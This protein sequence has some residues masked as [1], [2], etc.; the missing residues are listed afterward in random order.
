M[1]DKLIAY[2]L[3]K[4]G[5]SY[6]QIAEVLHLGKTTVYEYVKEQKLLLEEHRKRKQTDLDKAVVAV[7]PSRPLERGAGEEVP[8]LESLHI[9]EFTGDELLTKVFDCLDFEGRFLELIGKPSRLFSAIIWGMPK[10]GKSNFALRFA[11]YLQ[12]YFGRVLYIA[13]EEG[14]SVTLQEKFR[15]IGGSKVT[16]IE[17]RNRE[18]IRVFLG[19]RQEFGFVFIDSINNAGI[20][21]E[22]LELLKSENRHCSFI[23]VVQATKGG[24]FKGDQA[25]T[26]NC[27]FIIA[28]D[29]GMAYH[30]GR[31][32][33]NTELNIF[34][35]G[36]WY[37]KNPMA[38]EQGFSKSIEAPLAQGQRDKVL[39]GTVGDGMAEEDAQKKV[40]LQEDWQAALRKA[41]EEIERQ[42]KTRLQVVK[43]PQKEAPLTV[44]EFFNRLSKPTATKVGLA[45]FCYLIADGLATWWKSRHQK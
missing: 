35:G 42:R 39:N 12:E 9:K 17:S 16:V 5:K 10:G 8:V 32:N 27:D 1:S 40:R 33:V 4:E 41:K 26:H 11:D 3:F 14:E 25:L 44:Q 19:Q 2:R 13:A 15:D 31:F 34:E 20:D 29:K 43:M 7:P 28:V 23:C 38:V 22:F 24:K 18:E 30:Q 36:A 37:V 45:I 6:G 21:N